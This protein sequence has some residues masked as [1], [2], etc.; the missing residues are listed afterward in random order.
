MEDLPLGSL[1]SA[2]QTWRTSKQTGWKKWC[3]SQLLVVGGSASGLDTLL[4]AMEGRP[5]P[6]APPRDD[7]EQD[8]LAPSMNEQTN[9]N[10]PQHNRP[11]TNH[12]SSTAH[13][14]RCARSMMVRESRTIGLCG[15]VASRLGSLNRGT[16]SRQ[17]CGLHFYSSAEIR[18]ISE[19]LN[20]EKS[21]RKKLIRAYKLEVSAPDFPNRTSHS[22]TASRRRP[23][24]SLVRG[25]K[26]LRT[27]RSAALPVRNFTLPN[28]SLRPGL[29]RAPRILRG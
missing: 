3:G 23:G 10:N 26:Q 22:R 25:H 21:R 27:F 7:T 8:R 20:S 14:V 17:N 1:R 29:A 19:Q 28:L 11:A 13:F 15:C 6:A 18:P 12:T 2:I 5:A 9:D 4:E 24:T 16:P